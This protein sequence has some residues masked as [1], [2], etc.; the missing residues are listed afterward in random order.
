MINIIIL[1]LCALGTIVSM[2]VLGFLAYSDW[3]YD[4]I[5]SIKSSLQNEPH[6]AS[7]PS[8]GFAVVSFLM[9]Y[10]V[11]LGV[12]FILVWYLLDKG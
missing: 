4:V 9:I 7:A 11:A 6:I 10:A 2:S 8:S 3:R 12:F 5:P 1:I